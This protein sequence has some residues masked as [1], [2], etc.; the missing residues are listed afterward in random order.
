MKTLKDFVTALFEKTGLTQSEKAKA[1]LAIEQL[2]VELPEGVAAE[3][4]TAVLK[5]TLTLDQAKQN[6]DL[7]TYYKQVHFDKLA[8]QVFGEVPEELRPK[9]GELKPIQDKFKAVQG[10]YADQIKALKEAAKGQT[11]AAG[12]ETKEH[13]AK[14]ESELAELKK[15]N[16]ETLTQA[17]AREAELQAQFQQERINYLLQAEVNKLPVRDDIPGLHKL[18]Y[19]QF[20]EHLQGKGVEVQVEGGVPKLIV[21]RD[22]QVFPYKNESHLDVRFEDELRRI[23]EPYLRKAPPAGGQSNNPTQV[24]NADKLKDWQKE[25]MAQNQAALSNIPSTT[26][27]GAGGL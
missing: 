14:L 8:E 24:P 23:S 20:M 2:G 5:G 11:G 15:Q 21:R 10:W 27:G 1:L 22:G 9:L 19:Q 12:A 18:A 25:A 26:G 16:T 6:A 4:E 3:L 7:S 17:K 13:I